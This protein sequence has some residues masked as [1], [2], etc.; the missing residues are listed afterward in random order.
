MFKGAGAAY[1][2]QGLCRHLVT[3]CRQYNDYGSASRDAEEG[4]LNSLD[5]DDFTGTREPTSAPDPGDEAKG[6]LKAIAV[7][8]RACLQVSIKVLR[9]LVAEDTMKA[10]QVFRRF[11]SGPLGW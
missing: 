9:D 4:N 11:G 10:V 8:E 7:Y 3:M 5:F 2:S 6:T 1:V